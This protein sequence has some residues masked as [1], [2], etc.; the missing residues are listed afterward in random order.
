MHTYPEN[1]YANSSSPPELSIPPDATNAWKLK[2]FLPQMQIFFLD[3]NAWIKAILQKNP[4][5]A[6]Q[7]YKE[8]YKMLQVR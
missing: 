7:I 4:L 8:H 1:V 2:H 5:L 3:D 6:S